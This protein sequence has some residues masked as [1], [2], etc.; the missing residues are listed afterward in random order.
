M[1]PQRR[2][3]GE[4][5]AGTLSGRRG[6]E[7]PGGSSRTARQPQ[8]LLGGRGEPLE[9]G[10]GASLSLPRLLEAGGEQEGPDYPL[11]SPLLG[12]RQVGLPDG[13]CPA[14][15]ANVRVGGSRPPGQRVEAACRPR[16]VCR[17]DR[18]PRR[19]LRQA[20]RAR[21]ARPATEPY[22]HLCDLALPPVTRRIRPT[23]RGTLLRYP[24]AGICWY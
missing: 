15:R 13:L 2:A 9:P 20:Q 14:G 17:T 24:D 10:G 11:P 6:P 19:E 16:T 4:G 3:G 22:R 7:P 5:A 1:D 23:Q 21:P 8:T 18:E 12:R